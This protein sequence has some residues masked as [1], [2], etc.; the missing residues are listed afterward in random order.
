[1]VIER[2][3]IMAAEQLTE[4][5]DIENDEM[6]DWNADMIEEMA[7]TG[8]RPDFSSLRVYSRDWTV[9]TIYSQIQQGNIDLNPKFQR[10]NA[11]NDDKK[12]RLIES[13]IT[14]MPVPEIVFA[15]HPEEKR[16]FIVIDGKQRLLTIA[17]FINPEIG[18]W[19]KPALIGKELTLRHDLNGLTFDQMENES[20][21]VNELRAFQNADVRCTV[22]DSADQSWDIFYN[23]FYR[24]NSGS[25]PLS[26]QELRQVRNK[27]PFADYLMDITDESQ[28]IHRVL[29]CNVPDPRLRDAELI[30]RFL[31][32]VMFSSEY[33]GNLRRFLDDK[34]KYITEHWNECRERV[35][36]VYSDFN[37]S[38][39]KLE[40]ILGRENIGRIYPPHK[41]GG[42]LN[43]TLF[44][45]EAYYF[46]HLEDEVINGKEKHFKI[47]LEKFCGGN[48]SFR[49]SIRTSTSDLERYVNRYE[50]FCEFINKT[51]E[52]DIP[53][54]PLPKK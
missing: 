43:K 6:E 46:T 48:T 19:R 27:G 51:F 13:L 7:Q 40:E 4:N 53:V 29:R 45:V 16:S 44:E 22:V 52:T 8:P 26:S 28:P 3:G 39:G 14:G 5:D 23:I 36:Q 49:E 1:L 37:R 11:W 30:L 42:T 31:V 17:G 38:I 35:E 20:D 9:E 15:E 34:M 50:L 10:R 12:T 18:Y 21:Y 41:W 33:K 25:V 2:G 24:L 54:L 32:F 47:E